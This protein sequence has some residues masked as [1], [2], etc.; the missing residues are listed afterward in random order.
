MAPRQQLLFLV[1]SLGNP[2]LPPTP[3][4][5]LYIFFHVPC[6]SVH[7]HYC[8][9]TTLEVLGVLEYHWCYS[10]AT[11]QQNFS[12]FRSTVESYSSYY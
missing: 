11:D 9:D 1:L 5:C 8:T 7:I 10:S 6:A 3:D 12:A 2:A 4:V